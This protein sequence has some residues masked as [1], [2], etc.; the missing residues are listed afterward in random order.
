[1]RAM[2]ESKHTGGYYIANRASEPT[3]I[4]LKAGSLYVALASLGLAM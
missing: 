2:V 3:Q 1:M 4:S